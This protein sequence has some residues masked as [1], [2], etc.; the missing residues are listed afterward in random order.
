MQSGMSARSY[1]FLSRSLYVAIVAALLLAIVPVMLSPTASAQGQPVW[2]WGENDEGE[3]GN[4]TFSYEI[5][6]PPTQV[7]G[8]SNVT[9]QRVP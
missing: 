2:G 6:S 4:G 9:G 8:L 3:L 1:N 7:V 5:V